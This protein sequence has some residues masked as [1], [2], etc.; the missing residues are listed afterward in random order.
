MKSRLGK[1]QRAGRSQHSPPSF[2]K[3]PLTH[4]REVDWFS[5][6]ERRPGVLKPLLLT[7]VQKL[8]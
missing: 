4:E 1:G 7:S 2:R 8:I 5:A 6:A 3:S